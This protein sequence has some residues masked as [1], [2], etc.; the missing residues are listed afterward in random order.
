MVHIQYI[1][2]TKNISTDCL[3]GCVHANLTDYDYEPKEKEFGC[4]LFQK[5]PLVSNIQDQNNFIIKDKTLFKIIQD[6]NTS[7]KALVIP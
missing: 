4:T 7:F 5:L 1:K 2:G 3:T 6:V